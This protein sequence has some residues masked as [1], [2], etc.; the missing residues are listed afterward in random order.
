MAR[1]YKHLTTQEY[2]AVM[3]LRADLYS[4]RSIT[5]LFCRST[6]TISPELKRTKDS[7]VYDANLAYIQCHGIAFCHVVSTSFTRVAPRSGS[8][9]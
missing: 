7:G 1:I 6:S 8:G 3:P 9:S 4:S 5:K 2:P